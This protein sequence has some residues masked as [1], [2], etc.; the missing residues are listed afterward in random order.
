MNTDLC[1]VQ[2]RDSNVLCVHSIVAATTG[3]H[4]GDPLLAHRTFLGLVRDDV[5]LEHGKEFRLKLDLAVA[6]VDDVSNPGQNA[7]FLFDN[8]DNFKHG[9]ACRYDILNN[10]TTFARVNL[11]PPAQFH[12]AVFSF[13]EKRT[14][15]EDT[16]DFCP[17]NNPPNGRRN[18]DL[19]FV[20]L[21]V[22]R[23][24]SGEEMQVL[25]VLK[26][27]RTLEILVAVQSRRELKMPFQ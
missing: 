7:F 19:D 13:C 15:T 24:L 16:S 20:V 27:L 14:G 12:C 23:Y 4:D 8:I 11:K 1:E 17:H 22:L 3:L 6:T 10:E 21:K 26:N 25:G 5:E 9:S 18:D 2:Y